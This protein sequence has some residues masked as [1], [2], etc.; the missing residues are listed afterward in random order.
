[1]NTT[2]IWHGHSNFQINADGISILIDPFFTNNPSC[3][4]SWKTIQKPDIVLITHDHSDHVGDAIAI[5][6]STGALCGCIFGTA[7]K[8]I[9]HGMPQH[10]IIGE[11]G[12]NI[13][14]TVERKGVHIT[15]TQ[16]FHTSES[17]S[18]AGY[19]VTIPN[20]FTLY[21]PGDTS[22]FQ[23]MKTFGELYKLHLCLLPIGGFFTMD[24]Y[25]A[26]YAAKMLKCKMVIPMHW[27]TF[28]VLEQTPE[29]FANY[30]KVIA[31]DCKYI[32][33]N[34]NTSREL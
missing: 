5:C 17:G 6:K 16:S 9:Q 19:I 27:G 10:L 18:P 29:R 34:P 15:M 24:P 25:Q 2:I 33:M 4:T 21:H 23:T 14:G 22:I 32:A 11:V 31:P 7:D 20:N 3:T 8:L 30:L 1:M 28:P 13:G 12:F 26:A